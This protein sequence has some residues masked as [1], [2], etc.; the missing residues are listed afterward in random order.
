MRNNLIP[1]LH[2][3]SPYELEI[4]VLKKNFIEG[5]IIDIDNTLVPWSEKYADQRV[6]GLVNKL[7]EA[8]FKLCI[9]SNGTK[10]RVAVFNRELMLPAVHNAAKP[11][12]A[13]FNKA[14]RLLGTKPQHTAVIGDQIFTD[15][16]GGNRLGL[17]TILVVPLSSKEFLWTRFV[18]Q[19]EKI[20]LKKY[21]QLNEK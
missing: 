14:I 7:I 11:S 18:R 21:K 5:I 20:V 3:N 15:I 19:I 17:F 2:V 13:A 16:L 8:G 1:K 10:N 9:L 4:E 12:R 6:V